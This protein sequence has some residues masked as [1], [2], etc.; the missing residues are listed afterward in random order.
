MTGFSHEE[1]LTNGQVLHK[2]SNEISTRLQL[3][4]DVNA[5]YGR[6]YPHDHPDIPSRMSIFFQQQIL[7]ALKDISNKTMKDI[8]KSEEFIASDEFYQCRTVLSDKAGPFSVS[9]CSY[10]LE[11]EV[12]KFQLELNTFILAEFEKKLRLKLGERLSPNLPT[13]NWAD[14]SRRT[15]PSTYMLKDDRGNFLF[16]D[17]VRL[18]KNKIESN[19]DDIISLE[20]ND[21]K[22]THLKDIHRIKDYLRTTL[23]EILDK[24]DQVNRNDGRI[25]ELKLIMN[26]YVMILLIRLC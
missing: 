4:I 12:K 11:E 1:E 26:R 5:V 2:L 17:F 21:C 6:L 24:R 20:I 16:S 9:N 23:K 15:N 7:E 3:P 10:T 18:L 22:E 13:H 25:L 19:K 14:L 8:T